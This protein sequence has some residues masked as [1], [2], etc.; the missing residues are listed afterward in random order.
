MN[1]KTPDYDY[2]GP[3]KPVYLINELLAEH[4]PAFRLFE[5]LAAEKAHTSLL[6]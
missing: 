4:L 5:G 2:G 3:Y 1:R 6:N